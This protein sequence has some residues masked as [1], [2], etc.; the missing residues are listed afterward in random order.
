[1]VLTKIFL[2]FV[3]ILAVC[4]LGLGSQTQ[5]ASYFVVPQDYQKL[6]SPPPQVVLLNPFP[7]IEGN[8]VNGVKF[9][10][11]GGWVENQ[12]S[13]DDRNGNRK[14]CGKPIE[15][16]PGPQVL[17][18]VMCTRADCMAFGKAWTAHLKFNVGLR[19]RVGVDLSRLAVS[20]TEAEDQKAIIRQALTKK[21]PSDCVE[22]IEK[23]MYVNTCSA[24]GVRELKNKVTTMHKTCSKSWSKNTDLLHE[25]V[26]WEAAYVSPRR[27][28]LPDELKK[29]PPFLVDWA[30]DDGFWPPGTIENNISSWTWARGDDFD[31]AL[32]RNYSGED[33]RKR[34][35]RQISNWYERQVVVD[36][37]INA[38]LDPKKHLSELLTASSAKKFS[39]NPQ[40]PAGHRNFGLSILAGHNREIGKDSRVAAL[41]A[42]SALGVESK[43]NAGAVSD[44][45]EKLH[46]AFNPEADRLIESFLADDKVSRTEW[47]AIVGFMSRTPEDKSLRT[48]GEAAWQRYQGEVTQEQRLI[49]IAKY[50]CATGRAVDVRGQTLSTLVRE[51]YTA[52]PAQLRIK[53]LNQYPDCIAF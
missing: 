34:V 51:D 8:Q 3:L 29:L 7:K 9:S 19:E 18:I 23:A 50:D 16:Q 11:N 6:N 36:Q 32:F 40:E 33:F 13:T 49:D 5:A 24:G 22:S 21:K 17:H 15:V 31:G 27:C 28:F 35:I 12:C 48:C 4:A 14:V 30:V 46:C 20:K 53:M 41:L 37:L 47:Q 2:F 42:K 44:E 26:L 52:T 25:L 10:F 43:G 45:V 39:M 1:M 38:V